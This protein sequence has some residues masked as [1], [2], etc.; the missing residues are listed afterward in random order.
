VFSGK[1]AGRVLLNIAADPF[2][3]FLTWSNGFIIVNKQAVVRGGDCDLG[4]DHMLWKN[5][6][7]LFRRLH[8]YPDFIDIIQQTG[9]IDL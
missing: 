7:F 1:P 4:R 5:Y 9:M 8:R 6:I 3:S 2:S